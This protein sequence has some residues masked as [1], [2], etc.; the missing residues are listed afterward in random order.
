MKTRDTLPDNSPSRR[1]NVVAG[2][3]SLPL[4]ALIACL[5]VPQVLA[6]ILER[7]PYRT[8]YGHATD[9]ASDPNTA[10]DRSVYENRGEPLYVLPAFLMRPDLTPESER[11]RDPDNLLDRDGKLIDLDKAKPEDLA[12]DSNPYHVSEKWNEYWRKIHG[13]RFTHKDSPDDKSMALMLRYDQVHRIS[14]GP[15]SFFPPPY[16][17]PVDAEGHLYSELLGKIPAYKRPQYDGFA[18]MAF[19][20]LEELKISFGQ[21]KFPAKIVPEEQIMFRSVPHMIA[22]EYIIIPNRGPRGAVMQIKIHRLKDGI[23]KETWQKHWRTD[24]ADLVMAQTASHR[25]VTRYAQLHN[26]GPDREGELFWHPVGKEMDGV[27]VIEFANMSACE[28]FLMSPG[29]K[30]IEADEA[31][32]LD[33]AASVYWTAI[34]H[35]IIDKIAVEIPTKR[36]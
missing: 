18:Y 2:L 6:D 11:P 35:N 1:R 15:T 31:R 19:N 17:P 28:D 5:F 21:G 14:S 22:K 8:K 7:P 26:V 23:D 32:H 16:Q 27:T 34:N 3:A 13:M 4:L 33:M 20:T 30:K 25:F 29:Y 10:E 12:F 36:D 24:H 9:K